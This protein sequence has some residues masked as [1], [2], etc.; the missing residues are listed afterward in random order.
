MAFAQTKAREGDQEAQRVY[1]QLADAPNIH[2]MLAN[3]DQEV[4]VGAATTAPPST[5]V[6]PMEGD[7]EEQLS[8]ERQHGERDADEVMA[9][10]RKRICTM[11]DQAGETP[12]QAGETYSMSST[13]AVD[14]SLRPK[15]A[16]TQPDSQG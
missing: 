12:E 2:N 1:D 16:K 3:A 6:S 8:P 5:D 13:G 9:E 7:K 11:L 4:P 10:D 14:T 15:K